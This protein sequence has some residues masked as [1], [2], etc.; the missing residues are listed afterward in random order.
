M[1]VS[2]QCC[3]LVCAEWYLVLVCVEWC[4]CVCVLVCAVWY[5]CVSVWTGV[6]VCAQFFLCAVC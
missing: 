4:V 6:R 2:S 1:L 3:V 5:A